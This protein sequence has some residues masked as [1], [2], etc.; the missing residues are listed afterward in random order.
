MKTK[1]VSMEEA[2]TP[3]Q[4]VLMQDFINVLEFAKDH[5][6]KQ[7]NVGLIIEW[8]R[9]NRSPNRGKRR[10]YKGVKEYEHK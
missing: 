2:L 3:E 7:T 5:K 8:W 10:K 6:P 1:L 9:E 4:C